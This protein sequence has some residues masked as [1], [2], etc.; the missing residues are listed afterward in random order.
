MRSPHPEHT[1]L[2]A[3]CRK[4]VPGRFLRFDSWLLKEAN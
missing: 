4:S 1:A 2:D 3:A